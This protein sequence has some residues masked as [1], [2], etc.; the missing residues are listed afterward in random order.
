MGGAITH[1][2]MA[3]F[4][5][6]L[7]TA[8]TIFAPSGDPNS[9]AATPEAMANLFK[10]RPTDREAFI[11]MYVATWRVL[12]ADHFTFDEEKTRREGALSFDRGANP[13]GVVRQ[14]LA[15]VASG[16][17]K[18]ALRST[19]TA[20]SIRSCPSVSAKISRGRSPPRNS[21]SSKAWATACRA[22]R[23]RK[24]STRSTPMPDNAP[25]DPFAAWRDIVSQ[26][27]KSVNSLANR[28]MA[29]DQFS[30]SMNQ[31]MNVMLRAQQSVGDGMI[32]YLAALNLPSRADLVALGEQLGSIESQLSRIAVAIERQAAQPAAAQPAAS[33]SMSPPPA[34]PARRSPPR[35]KRP[36]PPAHS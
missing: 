18:E 11:D 28:E 31:M 12:A 14:M 27:E 32:K 23:G 13:Q 2:L 30:G 24:S 5:E 15:I 4:P 17:R 34:S 1:E 19:P 3:A 25:V 20:R 7:R 35:T 36:P 29:S 21:K 9:P 10:P 8:T 16:N 33:S 26:W 6:R 22:K